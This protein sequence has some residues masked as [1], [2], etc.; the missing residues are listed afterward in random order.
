MVWLHLPK[1]VMHRKPSEVKLTV[2][3]RT[4]L[5]WKPNLHLS[6]ERLASEMTRFKTLLS[7]NSKSSQEPYRPSA[8]LNLSVTDKVS[9][10][11]HY[12]ENSLKLRVPSVT[13]KL[14]KTGMSWIQLPHFLAKING[15]QVLFMDKV[16]LSAVEHSDKLSS[17]RRRMEGG[18]VRTNKCFVFAA[19]QLAF[20]EPYEFNFSKVFFEE[21][22]GVVKWLKSKHGKKSKT[23]GLLSKD[24]LIN[25]KH[26][27]LE[28]SDDPF[29]VR[30]RDNYEL[31][32]DEYEESQTRL[33]VLEERI[34]EFRRKNLLFP[35]EKVEELLQNLK[36]KNAEIYIQVVSKLKYEGVGVEIAYG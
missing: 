15:K 26:F 17:E 5:A 28:L 13:A 14:N 32:K 23:D 30:L 16:L 6:L 22:M 18:T 31:K 2:D 24:I 7:S 20:T 21:F 12:G 33:R 11:I 34:G 35:S 8:I 19:N 29:E 9:L 27:K 10:Y 4:K 36:K 3:Q 1:I 25:I